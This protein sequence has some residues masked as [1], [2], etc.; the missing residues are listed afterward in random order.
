MPND[1]PA[2]PPVPQPFPFPVAPQ[3]NAGLP[4]AP[5]YGEGPRG[6]PDWRRILASVV[7]FK[8]LVLAVVVLGTAAGYGLSQ[9]IRPRYLARATIWVD[10]VDPS[11]RAAQSFQIAGQLPISTGWTD[12]LTSDV[13]MDWVVREHRLY[14]EW[15]AEADSAAFDRFALHFD[16]F[17]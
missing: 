16:R 11:A 7:R 14:L 3:G 10:I 5:M 13:V 12:L 9:F 1:L 17:R 6:G 2:P 8:W 4:A 15:E